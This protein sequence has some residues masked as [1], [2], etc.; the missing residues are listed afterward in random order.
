MVLAWVEP[1]YRHWGQPTPMTFS[2][3]NGNHCLSLFIKL[4]NPAGEVC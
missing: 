1:V 4:A 2:K 3:I